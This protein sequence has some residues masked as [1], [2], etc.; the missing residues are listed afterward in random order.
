MPSMELL[1]LRGTAQT[2]STGWLYDRLP[3]GEPPVLSPTF[4]LNEGETLI[5]GGGMIESFAPQSKQA[6]LGVPLRKDV[7]CFKTIVRL[8]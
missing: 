5:V 4:S 3:Y 7:C 2:V 1:L 6:I 8:L